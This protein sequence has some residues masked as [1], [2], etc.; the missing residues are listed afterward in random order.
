MLGTFIWPSIEESQVIV[1]IDVHSLVEQISIVDSC[2][3]SLLLESHLS[4]LNGRD[5]RLVLVHGFLYGV[6]ER[7]GVFRGRREML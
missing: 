4:S 2:V 7:F 6:L 5:W 1:H 3:S